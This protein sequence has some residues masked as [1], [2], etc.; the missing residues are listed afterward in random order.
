[1][2]EV[3]AHCITSLQSVSY[4]YKQQDHDTVLLLY[5]NSKR[6]ALAMP[7]SFFT[8]PVMGIALFF[9]DFSPA[10]HTACA[11]TQ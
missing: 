4:A 3:I 9:C 11:I 5:L 8:S 2:Y 6:K 1:M 10:R 7:C